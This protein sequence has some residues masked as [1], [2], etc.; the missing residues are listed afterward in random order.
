MKLYYIIPIVLVLIPLILILVF[1]AGCDRNRN[2]IMDGDGMINEAGEI[3]N[4][5]DE[6]NMDPVAVMSL[7]RK[8][9]VL[10]RLFLKRSKKSP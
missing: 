1:L 6:N 8:A 10:R 4:E 7:F 5:R 9:T 3:M 2:Q